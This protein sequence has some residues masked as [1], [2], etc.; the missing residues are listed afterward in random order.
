[1]QLLEKL[2]VGAEAAERTGEV[3]LP[4]GWVE[5]K[6]G[7]D[8]K[9]LGPEGVEAGV[10]DL[11]VYAYLATMKKYFGRLS[12]EDLARVYALTIRPRETLQGWGTRVLSEVGM[13]NAAVEASGSVRHRITPQQELQIFL[14]GM[15]ADSRFSSCLREVMPQ[16][17]QLPA[18][19]RSVVTVMGR[20]QRVLEAQQEGEFEAEIR[21]A[22]AALAKGVRVLRFEETEQ[23]QGESS[24]LWIPKKG[25]AR[26][27]S[28]GLRGA[29]KGVKEQLLKTLLEEKGCSMDVLEGNAG[30]GGYGGRVVAAAGAGGGCSRPA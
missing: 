18:Q 2:Q 28:A 10:Q 24:G 15:A 26:A 1:L 8:A 27:V 23:Q 12:Q 4:E 30:K 20:M 3:Q 14:D 19:Q 5:M 22:S 21:K 17:R 6:E 25:G 29:D 7:A 11:P 13:V 9:Y 16:V